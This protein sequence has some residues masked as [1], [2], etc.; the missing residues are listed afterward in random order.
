M[1]ARSFC[2][3]VLESISYRVHRRFNSPRNRVWDMGVERLRGK[4]RRVAACGGHRFDT[5]GRRFSVVWDSFHAQ[6]LNSERAKR[7]KNLF[8]D[9]RNRQ[10]RSALSLALAVFLTFA[11]DVVRACPSCFGDQNSAEV[12]GM[13]WAIL[14]LLGVTGAVLAAI[15]AFI[16]F[17]RRQAMEFNRRFADRM[18]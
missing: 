10:T 16:F 18:N 3:D 5:R 2:T 12:Q 9:Y 14:S 8:S 6:I 15:T 7:V 11:C 17:L 1:E 13:K 4:Q